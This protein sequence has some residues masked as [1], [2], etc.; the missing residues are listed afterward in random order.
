MSMEEAQSLLANTADEGDEGLLANTAD[1]GEEKKHGQSSWKDSVVFKTATFGANGLFFAAHLVLNGKYLSSLGEDGPAASALMSTYQSVILGS[2]VGA[3]LGTGLDFG[4]AVGRKDYRS[5]G[6]VAKTATILSV[7]F[8]GLSAS[9]MFAT[10]GIFPLIFEEGTAKFASDF[11][12]GYAAGSV[13]LLFLIVGPQ[14]AFIEGDCYVPPASMFSVLSL[15]GVASYFLGFKADLG[16]LGI[17][18]GGTIGSSFISQ[19]P[20]IFH[21]Y[22]FGE[23]EIG[24]FYI[25]LSLTYVAGS[26]VGKKLLKKLHINEVLKIGYYAFNIGA[27]F[28]LISGFTNLPLLLMVISISILTFGNGFLI[29]LGTAGVISSFSGKVGYASGLL[30][31]LQLGLAALSSM[32]IGALSQNSIIKMGFCI[33]MVTLFGFIIHVCLSPKQQSSV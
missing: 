12:V 23:R 20:F 14:I 21:S 27:L 22:G 8:G 31:F 1:D 33:F 7:G 19:S 2:G 10:K 5:A 25:T 4:S 17:G 18:L 15:S 26:I 13:P 28:L 6:N 11:F 24:M 29:P 30:G 32:V 3:L 16:A 9:A